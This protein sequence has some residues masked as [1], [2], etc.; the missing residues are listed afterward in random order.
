MNRYDTDTKYGPIGMGIEIIST[1]KVDNFETLDFVVTIF[2]PY[3]FRESDTRITHK[4]S[5][6]VLEMDTVREIPPNDR[7]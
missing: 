7:T 2:L 6:M 3:E 1:D 5:R 4:G